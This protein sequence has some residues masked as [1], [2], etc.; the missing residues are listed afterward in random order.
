MKETEAWST[1]RVHPHP[2][3]YCILLMA[4]SKGT[5]GVSMLVV[6]EELL[7]GVFGMKDWQ[8]MMLLLLLPSVRVLEIEGTT[9]AA[10]VCPSVCLLANHQA[11]CPSCRSP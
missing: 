1:W 8:G 2:S 10:S 11:V 3:L 7:K 4:I 9:T 5:F 6:P